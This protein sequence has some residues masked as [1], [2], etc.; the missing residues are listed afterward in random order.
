M[1]NRIGERLAAA[2]GALYVVLLVGGDDM[3]NPA[4]EIPEPDASLREVS[5]YLHDADTAGFWLGRSIGLVALCALLV[6]VVYVSRRIREREGQAGVLSG[7]ALAAGAVAVALQMLA[8]PAQFAAVQGAADGLDAQTAKALLHMSVSFSL[9][10]LPLSVFLGA[11]AAATLR[12]RLLPRWL[13]IASALLAVGF[14]AGIIGQPQ[15]PA[16]VTYMAFAL[17]YLWFIATSVVLVR[18]AAAPDA[19]ASTVRA[20]TA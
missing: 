4:G 19:A 11:V 5:S 9:S 2:C 6:F 13:G 14:V 10:F 20:A 7:I 17:S 12:Y 8:A 18:R 15:E 3:I 1:K 16:V